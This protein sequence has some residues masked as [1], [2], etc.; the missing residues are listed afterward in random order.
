[1]YQV[2]NLEGVVLETRDEHQALKEI[3]LGIRD[4]RQLFRSTPRPGRGALWELWR[5]AG[6]SWLTVA[7]PEDEEL[8]APAS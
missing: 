6:G 4:G 8:V 3:N 5:P 2:R 1:M 7:S